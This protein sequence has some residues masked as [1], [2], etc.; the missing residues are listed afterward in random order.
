MQTPYHGSD[1]SHVSLA[2]S[3][4]VRHRLVPCTRH[5]SRGKTWPPVCLLQSVCLSHFTCLMLQSD[6]CLCLVSRSVRAT[7]L[8]C[9][10]YNPQSKTYC[11]RLQVLCPEHSRDPKVRLH[12]HLIYQL[13][14]VYIL[15]YF[16]EHSG[17]F[18]KIRNMIYDN[19]I[20]GIILPMFLIFIEKPV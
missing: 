10:V 1:W 18:G 2:N 8:F 19:I 3:T 15:C 4:R 13:L 14:I 7:R 20:I 9:D 6:T 16:K 12:P 17:S 5:V 11:K